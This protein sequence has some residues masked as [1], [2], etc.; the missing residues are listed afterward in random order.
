MKR[1]EGKRLMSLIQQLCHGFVGAKTADD[2]E[3]V[4]RDRLIML[5]EA[6]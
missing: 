2:E 3:A 4:S 1:G 6:A 5:V